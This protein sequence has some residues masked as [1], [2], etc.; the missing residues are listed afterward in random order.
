LEYFLPSLTHFSKYA[1]IPSLQ[2]PAGRLPAG[3]K[4][5]DVKIV[6]SAATVNGIANAQDG[7]NTEQT[8]VFFRYL[9]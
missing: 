2:V 6:D 7:G 8:V 4:G 9:R 3:P 1:K 5:N